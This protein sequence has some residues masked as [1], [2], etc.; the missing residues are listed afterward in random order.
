VKFIKLLI[1]AGAGIDIES[2]TE[3]TPLHVAVLDGNVRAFK[4]LIDAGAKVNLTNIN[5][6]TIEF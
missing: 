6:N 3:H 4:A 5:S 1:D 2:K